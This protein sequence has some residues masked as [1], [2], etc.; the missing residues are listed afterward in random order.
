MFLS[1]LEGISLLHIKNIMV[2]LCFV[3]YMHH[4]VLF[5]KKKKKGLALSSQFMSEAPRDN[6][7][8]N[9]A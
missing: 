6:D 1:Q 8:T 9:Q 3:L 5:E 2:N 7:S 4:F